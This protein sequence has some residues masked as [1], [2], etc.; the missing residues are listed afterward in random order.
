[1]RPIAK[2]IAWSVC[3]SGCLLVTT[4]PIDMPFGMWTRRGPMNCV[5]RGDWI[6]PQKGVFYRVIFGHAHSGPRSISSTSFAFELATSVVFNSLNM[7]SKFLQTETANSFDQPP[8]KL[9]V[10]KTA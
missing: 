7:A 2:Y 3:M 1:M 9:E 8:F 6:L 5:L 10:K 4:K